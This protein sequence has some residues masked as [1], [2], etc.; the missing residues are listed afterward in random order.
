MT[1]KS[2]SNSK[3]SKFQFVLS[4]DLKNFEFFLQS[5]NIPGWSYGVVEQRI[6][7]AKMNFPSDELTFNDLM[8][9]V[10]C[11]AEYN[12]WEEVYQEMRRGHNL[13]IGIMNQEDKIFQGTL[14]LNSGKNNQIAKIQFKDMI[15]TEVGDMQ[16]DLKSSQNLFYS[17]TARFDDMIFVRS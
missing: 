5:V 12:G 8:F 15:I 3:T 13:Q 11:D 2:V 6:A 10:I 7:G 4:S 17:I 9:E 16:L 1:S 14:I